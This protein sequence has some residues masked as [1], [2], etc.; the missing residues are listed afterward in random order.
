VIFTV[1]PFAEDKNLGRE[2]NGIM[3]GLGTYDWACLLDHDMAFTTSRW[4]AQLEAAIAARPDGSFTAVTNRIYSE[5]QKDKAAARLPGHSADDITVHRIIGQRRLTNKS[6]LDVTEQNP[7]WGG[8]LMLVSKAA[9]LDAGGF[10]DGMM[11][12]DHQ[13]HYALRRA[14]RHIFCI[15]G[16]YVYHYRGTSRGRDV[17]SYPRA[18]SRIT[19]KPCAHRYEP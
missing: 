15:E 1:I 17:A 4:H 8:V 19:R 2:Y 13:F 5:W 11:C 10:E 14:G 12:V 6:L 16:L 18:R 7:G 3:A 9:W